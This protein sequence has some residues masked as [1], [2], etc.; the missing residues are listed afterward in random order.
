MH[1][2]HT[3]SR[4]FASWHTDLAEAN[5]V[6]ISA[7]AVILCALLGRRK[8]DIA[9]WE[10]QQVVMDVCV[11]CLRVISSRNGR[12]HSSPVLHLLA[13]LVLAFR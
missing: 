7:L 6:G 4:Y 9:I 5:E 13:S 8:A 2:W 12:L 11:D 10:M 1:A 3:I